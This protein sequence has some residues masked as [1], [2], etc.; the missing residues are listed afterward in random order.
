MSEAPLWQRRT[1]FYKAE[2]Q[3]YSFGELNLDGNNQNEVTTLHT[4]LD[5]FQIPR[6]LCIYMLSTRPLFW[7]N[8]LKLDCP[9]MYS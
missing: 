8:I 6:L 3:L 2:N 7:Y 9:S 4:D 5:D 1:G